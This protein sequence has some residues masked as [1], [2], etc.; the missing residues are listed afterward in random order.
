MTASTSRD[1]G[2]RRQ[3]FIDPRFIE[4]STGISLRMNPPVQHPDPV[5]VPDRPWESNGIGAYNTALL[6][7][8][9]FRLWY[10]AG[11][12]G[13]LPSERRPSPGLCRV[14]RRPQLAQAHPRPHSLPGFHR[15]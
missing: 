3:L 12:K 10:D 14:R 4:R 2:S 11:V 1:V 13:G 5:L 7:D 15:Q 9:R 8:G 6:E